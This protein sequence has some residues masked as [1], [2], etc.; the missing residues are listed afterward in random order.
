MG[1]FSLPEYFAYTNSFTLVQMNEK[2]AENSFTF[3]TMVPTNVQYLSK[4]GNEFMKSICFCIQC[5][6]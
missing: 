6:Q 4:M 1:N 5:L 2:C 3:E